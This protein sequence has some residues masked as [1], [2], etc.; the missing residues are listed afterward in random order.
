MRPRLSPVILLMIVACRHDSHQG[1]PGSAGATAEFQ[2]PA[3]VPM[4]VQW[5]G[6]AGIRRGPICEIGHNRG[7]TA[8]IPGEGKVAWQVTT[9]R[10]RVIPKVESNTDGGTRLTID[11]P[12]GARQVE[13]TGAA[14]QGWSL[15]LGD[16]PVHP[17]ID[18][19]LALGRT[20]KYQEA[21]KGLEA[22]QSGLP[23]GPGLPAGLPDQD[24]GPVHAAIGRMAL[25]LG[26]VDRAEPAFRASIAAARDD[27][28]V[29]DVVQDGAALLWALVHLQQRYADARALLD[30]MIPFGGQYPEGRIWLDYHAGLLAADTGDVR[31]AL[32]KYRAAERAARRLDRASLAENA[33]MEV[34]RQLIRV[35]RS[36]EAL[37]L[38]RALPNPADPCARASHVLNLAWALVEQAA[39]AASRGRDTTV[40]EALLAA[41]RSTQSCPDPHRRLLAVINGAEYALEVNDDAEV[42]RLLRAME[43]AT[44]D[45]DV[46]LASWRADVL[47]RW[48][49][50]Q[51]KPGPAL[52]AFEDQIRGAHGAGL[53]EEAFRG[54]VGA[55]RAL[56]ALGRRRAAVTRLKTARRLLEDMLRGI[57]L[58][59]G[60][61]SFLGGHDDGV[62]Y[63]VAALVDSGAVREA[64]L[65]A[66]W[67]RAA[68]LAHAARI[69]RLAGLPPELRRRWDDAV[70][71]YQRI[72]G[73]I[74]HEAE[75]DWTVPRANL[76]Q[77]RAERQVRAGQGRAALDEAYRLLVEGDGSRDFRLSDPI[78]RQIYLGF[79]P[80][81]TG[82]Y[83]FAA[84]DRGVSVRQ[85]DDRALA[86]SAGAAKVLALFGPQL[87]TARRVRLFPYGASDRIDWHAV[88]WNGRPLIA[89]MEVEY[90]L[91]IPVRPPQSPPPGTPPTALV[92]ANPTGDLPAAVP[93]ADTVARMLS[94]WRITRLEGPNAT[95][96]AVLAALSHAR[97]FH[98]AGHAEIAGPQGLSSALLLTG[99]ARVEL[100]DLL[101]APSVPDLVILSACEA[102][103]TAVGD[104]SLM[105]LA[106]A[107][108]AAGSQV[109]I[110]PTR[111]VGDMAARTFVSA[112][113]AAFV[114]AKDGPVAESVRAAFRCAVLAGSEVQGTPDSG[115]KDPSGWESFRMLVP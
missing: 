75:N 38:L 90:G 5:A 18:S 19:L 61:G 86:S 52:A 23:A 72:R 111:P 82:W 101:A 98:Y 42:A 4:A 33:S 96:V 35:G 66:R 26:N 85:I 88:P 84:T 40:V 73:E 74:E 36:E 57:P 21:L 105:G 89:S 11:I 15:R 80:G 16:A 114:S 78:A 29:A 55:G 59:E 7:L 31:T 44:P 107:F 53:M 48:S 46:L 108:V 92:V 8:W 64:F 56:L 1:A 104:P 102:A 91:D 94:G 51:K 6:C 24:R 43:T 65:V 81:P 63:L 13:I 32:E 103:G 110:A 109:V 93:E 3:A 112:F 79:F 22:L 99:N 54:E 113:Y 25:A 68:E 49:L 9:D 100:G 67:A 50:R 27:G 60:R 45:R 12:I 70:G 2:T 97:L 77:L 37:T 10:G 71:R 41:E 87:L 95:R 83:A 115:R 30:E 58:A 76:A 106:Q 28:R 17:K 14:G 47:G 20:G 34:A 39:H 69:D 62:R